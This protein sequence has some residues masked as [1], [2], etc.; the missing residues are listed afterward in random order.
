MNALIPIHV[1]AG[2][3]AILTDSATLTLRR[4]AA[5]KMDATPTQLQLEI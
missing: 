5:V 2:L 1:D 4:R 3:I